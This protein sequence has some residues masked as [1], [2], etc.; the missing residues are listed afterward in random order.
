MSKRR[1]SPLLNPRDAEKWRQWS[2]MKKLTTITLRFLDKPAYH[3]T[4]TVVTA[5]TSTTEI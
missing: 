4:V 1:S 5:N 3:L 2:M